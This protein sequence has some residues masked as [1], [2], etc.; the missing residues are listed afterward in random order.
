MD[1]IEEKVRIIIDGKEL[2][3]APGATILDV[4]RQNDIRIPTLCHHPDLTPWGGCRL[5][6]VEVD[7]APK[8]A[9][10]CVTPVRDGMNV[11]T[12]NDRILESRKAVLEFLFAERNHNCMFCPQSGDCELQ[13]LAYEM[14][15][16]HLT[17]SSSYQAFPTD[18]TS[19]YMVMDHNRCILCGRCVRGCAELAGS[20]VLNFHNR[21]P[22]S[23][24]GIDLSDRRE[25]SSC[26]SCGLC[27]QLCPTGAISSRYRSHYTVKGHERKKRSAE[28]VCTRCGL[29]C[30]TILTT[31]GNTLLKI[32]GRT[33]LRNGR[34]DKGQLCFK[35][36][37]DPLKEEKRLTL[38]LVLEKKGKWK[39]AQWEEAIRIAS[40]GLKSLKEKYGGKSLVCIAS[41]NLSNEEMILFKDFSRAIESGYV[42]TLDGIHYRSTNKGLESVGAGLGE[43]QWKK[44]AEADFVLLVGGDP[45]ETQ[46]MLSS[47]IR[48]GMVERGLRVAAVGKSDSWA[49]PGCIGISLRPG[50]EIPF[51]KSFLAMALKQNKGSAG[52][53]KSNEVERMIKVDVE[54]MLNEISASVD[55]RARLARIVDYFQA[56]ENPLIVAGPLVTGEPE[57]VRLAAQISM[58][59]GYLEEKILRLLLLKTSGNSGGAWKMNIPSRME[60]ASDARWK[61]G[62]V[63]LGGVA[64]PFFLPSFLNGLE[65]LV[66]VASFHQKELEDRVNVLLPRPRWVEGEGTFTS[67][68]GR[69]SRYAAGLLDPPAGVQ[70]AWKTLVDLAEGCGSPLTL[71]T[72]EQVSAKGREMIQQQPLK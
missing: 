2:F 17:L 57:A 18:V 40:E 12:S 53:L 11:V 41:S 32:E 48:Q 62:V 3:T 34:P 19:E 51:L 5:C 43:A 37:F 16:D 15:M 46:P 30:P 52:A 9:A 44:I 31:A 7:A 10:S 28:S 54:S 27:M 47:L 24:I 42:D 69:E 68:D 36:R 71:K 29:L 38:P 70:G 45:W 6:M 14:Q 60:K 65:F 35:G 64:E 61:G 25:G 55:D 67:L 8:L 4:A 63:V 22:K 1:R 58:M 66:V 21:G 33:S 23:L 20:Y 59:K 49:G 56:A 72:W 13:S 26:L 50:K 39:E